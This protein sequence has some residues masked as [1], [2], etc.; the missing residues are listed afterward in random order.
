M[1]NDFIENEIANEFR[2][3]M[4]K[5]EEI[6]K[7]NDSSAIRSDNTENDNTI[8]TT[9][10]ELTESNTE[11]EENDEN[12]NE[13]NEKKDEWVDIL[14]SG[15]IM[16]KTIIEGKPGTQPTRTEKCTINYTCSLEDGTIVENKTNFSFFLGESDVR[17]FV[18]LK[19]IY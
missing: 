14:G 17:F 10:K 13:T 3:G 16:K 7:H 1:S 15:G 11:S 18:T 19:H 9:S 4:P 8:F 6:I 5:N 2:S 12:V